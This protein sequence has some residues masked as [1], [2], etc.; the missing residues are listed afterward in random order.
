[1]TRAHAYAVRHAYR[2]A[3]RADSR[4]PYNVTGPQPRARHISALMYHSP[5]EDVMFL[6]VL[7]SMPSDRLAMRAA[8]MFLRVNTNKRAAIAHGIAQMEALGAI[9]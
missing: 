3:C 6:S 4:A 8:E 1:M 2:A 7:I 5:I 9:A